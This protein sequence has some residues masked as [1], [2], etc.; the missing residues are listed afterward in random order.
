MVEYIKVYG[1]ENVTIV[2]LNGNFKLKKKDDYEHIVLMGYGLSSEL[3]ELDYEDVYKI[4]KNTM[5]PYKGDKLTTGTLDCC[6][7]LNRKMEL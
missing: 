1:A 3:A 7:G 2:P 4:L 6:Y 5:S